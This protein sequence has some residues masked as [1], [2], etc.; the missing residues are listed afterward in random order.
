MRDLSERL[1]SEIAQVVTRPVY[2]VELSF[3]VPLYLSTGGL[4]AWNGQDW[5]PSGA[6]VE[7]LHEL[8]GGSITGRLTLANSDRAMGALV[9]GEGVRDRACRVWQIYGGAPYDSGDAVLRFDG[10]M[11]AVEEIGDRVVIALVSAGMSLA[12]APRLFWAPPMCNHLPPPGTVLLW[13]GE[14]YELEGR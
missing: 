11:D 8:P 1:Q 12:W 3:S 4:V 14:K 10:A 9:L 7:S 13:N 5:L 2:L 6:T